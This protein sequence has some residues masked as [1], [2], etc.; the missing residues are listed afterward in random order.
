MS[1]ESICEQNV[2][3][4]SKDTTLNEV[5][6]HFLKRHVGSLVVTEGFNGKRV[7]AGII[8]DRDLALAM[9]SSLNAP[10]LKVSQIMKKNP[11]TAKKTDGVFATIKTMRENGVKRLPVVN[12]DGALYG[13]ISA[14]DLLPMLADEISL[15]SQIQDVQLLHEKGLKRP[16][17][18]TEIIQ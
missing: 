4:I 8:T 9:A 5:S 14:D 6:K 7:P 13:V 16:Q 17:A 12:E 3:T 10:K 11:I 15:L 2:A 1:I 18:S